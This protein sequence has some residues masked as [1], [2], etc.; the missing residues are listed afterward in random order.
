MAKED[1]LALL[2]TSV[3]QRSFEKYVLKVVIFGQMES[4]DS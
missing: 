2:G 3:T 4:Y 1:E